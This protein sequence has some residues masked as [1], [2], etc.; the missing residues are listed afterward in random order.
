MEQYI[1]DNL[2]ITLN[3]KYKTPGCLWGYYNDILYFI[4]K[5]IKSIIQ[6]ETKNDKYCIKIDTQN[7]SKTII[8]VILN[9]NKNINKYNDYI[10]DALKDDKNKS[11]FSVRLCGEKIF[12]Y[13][14]FCD[15]N[16]KQ[17]NK[18]KFEI[19]I[20]FHKIMIYIKPEK[21]IALKLLDNKNNLNTDEVV[22]AEAVTL[23]NK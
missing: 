1:Y 14:G 20:P 4:V 19:S 18:S 13:A 2:Q 9:K 6:I 12:T 5:N 16:L 22:I 23:L 3:I 7:S 8:D 21:I 10:L 11:Y 17:L 15:I